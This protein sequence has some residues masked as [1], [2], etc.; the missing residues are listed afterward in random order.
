MTQI[1]MTQ[2]EFL[3]ILAHELDWSPSKTEEMVDA[4]VSILHEKL[5]ESA[6]ITFQQVG[7]FDTQKHSECVRVDRQNKERFLMPPRITVRFRPAGTIF[8]RL[9]KEAL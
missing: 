2:N 5:S 9:R 3:S 8:E 7:T 1:N 6:E 4:T